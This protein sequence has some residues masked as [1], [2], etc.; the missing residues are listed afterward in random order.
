ML[1]LQDQRVAMVRFASAETAAVAL[2]QL[3]GSQ[4]C[5]ESLT[6]TAMNP[7]QHSRISKRV[8]TA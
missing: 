4:I 1:L 5:G 3:N 8:R 7:L 6:I 2:E